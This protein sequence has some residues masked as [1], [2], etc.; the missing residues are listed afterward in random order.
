MCRG[1][2]AGWHGKSPMA[3]HAG[4][5]RIFF[6][7]ESQDAVGEICCRFFNKKGDMVYQHLQN[8]TIAISLKIWKR[9]RLFAF[10]YGSQKSA[11]AILACY[12]LAMSI[13][14]YGWSDDS[15]NAWLDGDRSFH[16]LIVAVSQVQEISKLNLGILFFNSGFAAMYGGGLLI[17]KPMKQNWLV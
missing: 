9:C 12:E 10:A 5:Q 4:P 17:W 7:L 6:A 11:A 3:G 2:R 16:F 13:I 1:W 8:R 15:K 14:C